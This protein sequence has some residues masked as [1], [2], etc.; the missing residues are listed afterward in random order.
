MYTSGN[1]YT[2]CTVPA[3]HIESP[4]SIVN[5]QNASAKVV[6]FST[7]PSI[8]Y[9]VQE[10]LT[11]SQKALHSKIT[12]FLFFLLFKQS[13]IHF[14]K[15]ICNI[16]FLYMVAFYQRKCFTSLSNC[17]YLTKSNTELF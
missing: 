15:Q 6:W 13:I 12:F 9:F 16:K 17:I 5:I 10:T 1:S 3:M 7:G 11:H 2:F 8:N 14:S 4:G